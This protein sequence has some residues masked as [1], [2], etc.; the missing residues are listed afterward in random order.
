M[1][2]WRGG[3]GQDSIYAEMVSST[4]YSSSDY[5]LIDGFT[6]ANIQP[7]EQ[8]NQTNT[9]LDQTITKMID[10]T[11]LRNVI[12]TKE[13]HDHILG[14]KLI[15]FFFWNKNFFFWLGNQTLRDFIFN[16]IPSGS[17]IDTIH[18]NCLEQINETINNDDID[19]DD[20][21]NH[22]ELIHAAIDDLNDDPSHTNEIFKNAL[23]ELSHQDPSS[24]H[25]NLGNFQSQ[26]STNVSHNKIFEKI[27][28]H[29]YL[30]SSQIFHQ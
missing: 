21:Y 13:G 20:G 3:I 24:L 7:E 17:F 8:Q 27:E 29:I 16:E 2:Q 30:F 1:C 5:P 18:E 28:S 14:K 22:E 10:L 25:S 4:M 12:K 23:N 15:N 19:N 26:Q 11:S 6:N 9:I